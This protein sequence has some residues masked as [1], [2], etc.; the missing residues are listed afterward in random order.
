MT[1]GYETV[2]EPSYKGEWS[3]Y[4]DEQGY[5]YWYN[6]STGESRYEQLF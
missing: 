1:E 6:Y 2:Q 5:T 3:Q 4:H